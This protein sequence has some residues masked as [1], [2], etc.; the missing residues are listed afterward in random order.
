MGIADLRRVGGTLCLDFVNTLDWRGR[1]EPEESLFAYRDLLEW[2]VLV[3]ALSRAD[4]RRLSGVSEAV[5]RR[6]FATAIDLREAI[7]RIVVALFHKKRPDRSDLARLGDSVAQAHAAR[8]LEEH[9]G[10]LKWSWPASDDPGRPLWPIALSA[11][12]LL[13]SDKVDLISQCDGPECGWF[14]LDTS[15][16]R[17]RRWC[18]MEGCG[19]RA[20]AR[21]HY[22]R[23][24]DTD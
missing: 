13:A 4:A 17:K 8:R 18:S 12:E 1:D 21:R 6:E 14:F 19:N 23:S 16:N 5:A 3:G 9:G 10:H 24:R 22:A 7:H 11:S 2:G 20:K 15:K